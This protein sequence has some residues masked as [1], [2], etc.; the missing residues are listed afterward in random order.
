MAQHTPF[1]HARTLPEGEANRSTSWVA[2]SPHLS[3]DP[4]PASGATTRTRLSSPSASSLCVGKG[5]GNQATR[6]RRQR[7]PCQ[8]RSL[9]QSDD[10]V[11]GHS[12]G[13]PGVTQNLDLKRCRQKKKKK[14]EKSLCMKKYRSLPPA[15]VLWS[16]FQQQRGGEVWFS[17]WSN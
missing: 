8:G 16:C 11:L 4:C 12:E 1:P 9:N 5:E 13:G 2:A 17:Y 10:E 3:A 14:K 6:L 7:S 15:H